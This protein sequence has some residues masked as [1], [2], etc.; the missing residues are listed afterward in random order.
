MTRM[1]EGNQAT[2]K[3][4]LT[5]EVMTALIQRPDLRVVKV[6]D[7]AADNGSC[8]G[9]MLPVGQEVLDFYHAAEHLGQTTSRHC[10]HQCG[11]KPIVS[12]RLSASISTLGLHASETSFCRCVAWL[13]VE[14]TQSGTIDFIPHQRK[15]CF[16]E[17]CL[18][19]PRL[20]ALPCAL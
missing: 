7:G 11:F 4:Q 1:P 6:A 12:H 18:S 8:L 9:E 5:A 20:G 10:L 2:L 19:A 14:T 17:V 15:G 3:S 13:L 16:G